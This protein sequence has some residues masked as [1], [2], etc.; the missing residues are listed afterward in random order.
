MTTTLPEK[1]QQTSDELGDEPNIISIPLLYSEKIG[2]KL[3]NVEI[4]QNIL[5]GSNSLILGHPTNGVLGVATGIGGGQ[6]VLGQSGS[7]TTTELARRRYDWDKA[8]E[9]GKGV[10]SDNIDISQG[11]ITL[12]N[13]TIR[14]IYLE[15]KSK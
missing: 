15:H 12:G 11:F 4:I 9:L 7:T 3:R 5:T 6:I 2:V 13:V 8:S 10:K 14:N 1:L